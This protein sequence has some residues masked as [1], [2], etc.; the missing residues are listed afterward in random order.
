MTRKL[1]PIAFA[2]LLGAGP[3]LADVEIDGSFEGGVSAND[4]GSQNQMRSDYEAIIGLAGS[5]ALD[6]GGTLR[7]RLEQSASNFGPGRDDAARFGGREAWIG[8]DSDLGL[9]RAGKMKSPLYE[10]LDGRYRDTGARFLISEYGLGQAQRPGS[11]VRYDSPG[12]GGLSFSALYNLE[13]QGDNDH[14]GFDLAARYAQA[15]LFVDGAY[16]ERNNADGR[17]DLS[18]GNAARF[19]S[20]NWFA[21]AGY[22]FANGLG[23]NGGYKSMAYTPAGGRKAE[24]DLWFAQGSYNSGKHGTYLT[25]MQLG[26]LADRAD[27][28]A[29]AVAARYNYSLSKQS[30]AYV[31]GRYVW[32]DANAGYGPTNDT[33]DYLGAP[34]KDTSRVMA[35]LKTHF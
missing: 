7:W 20:R 10:M 14:Y 29:Q 18:V 15:G 5:D 21:S 12:F 34:G 26:D 24:Q 4:M 33:T 32:N 6:G 35:G 11:S 19:D 22:N 30:L 28:G 13:D 25:Y 23:V 9:V 3:A 16:Q 8:Y 2:L 31:E 17:D 1:T 27:S